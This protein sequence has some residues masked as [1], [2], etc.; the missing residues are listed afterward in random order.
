MSCNYCPR[1]ISKLCYWGSIIG[2]GLTKVL[3]VA[4]LFGFVTLHEALSPVVVASPVIG[5]V[6]VVL[7][8][9]GW[10]KNFYSNMFKAMKG[11]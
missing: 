4:W 5:S 7:S 6:H 2:V 8:S 9:W 3:L 1:W 11:D 10:T